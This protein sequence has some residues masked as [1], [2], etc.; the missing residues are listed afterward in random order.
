MEDEP[1]TAAIHLNKDLSDVYKSCTQLMMD[2]RRC[3]EERTGMQLSQEI[4]RL[5]KII[6][7]YGFRKGLSFK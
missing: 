5:R 4:L 6:Q 2:V 7:E 3:Y 1:T